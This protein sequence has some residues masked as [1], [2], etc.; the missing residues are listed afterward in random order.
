MLYANGCSLTEGSE[1]GNVKFNYDEAKYGPNT[2]REMDH[3]TPEH[4]EHIETHSWPYIVKKTLGIENHFNNAFGGSSNRR[5]VRVT[6]AD[7][8]GMITRGDYKPEEILVVIGWSS[9]D[10][11]E[12]YSKDH[13]AQIVPSHH[14][15]K[16]N[17]VKWRD[18]LAYD[19]LMNTEFA[20]VYMRHL[21]DVQ[22][23]KNYL[24]NRGVKYMF[25]YSLT[26][27][28]DVQFSMKAIEDAFNDY[29]ELQS[30]IDM[31]EYSKW[32]FDPKFERPEDPI[33]FAFNIQNTSFFDSSLKR[34]YRVGNGMHPL[35]DSHKRWGVEMANHIKQQGIL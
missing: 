31:A 18:Y 23:L 27:Y 15:K 8:E 17:S 29:P 24:E 19:G 6:M 5:I 14:T 20:E 28:F 32:F 2:F 9:F 26:T 4:I 7:V 21:L 35:E 10:R 1:L 22:L 25:S 33:E 11:F 13:F 30:F 3:L 34:K 12:T 16:E